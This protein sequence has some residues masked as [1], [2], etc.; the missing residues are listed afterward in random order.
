MGP[1]MVAHSVM[2]MAV[3]MVVQ[4]VAYWVWMKDWKMGYPTAMR[5]VVWMVELMVVQLVET[6]ATQMVE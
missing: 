6:M 1:L 2:L 5:R 3:M 4:S